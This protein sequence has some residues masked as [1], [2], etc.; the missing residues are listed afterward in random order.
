M[1][2][3]SYV[4]VQVYEQGEPDSPVAVLTANEADG[5]W[6]AG[7]DELAPGDYFVQA[8]QTDA[9]ATPA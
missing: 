4:T 9:R 8:H 5:A 1:T 2:D 6:T 3:S 7:S